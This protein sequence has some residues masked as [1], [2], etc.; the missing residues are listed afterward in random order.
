[1]VSLSSNKLH[2]IIVVMSGSVHTGQE[3]LEKSGNLIF[4]QGKSGKMEISEECVLCKA[5]H[6]CAA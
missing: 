6:K 4:S 2:S 5:P 3:K 1:M